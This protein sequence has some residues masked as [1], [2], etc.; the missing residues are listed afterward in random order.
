MMV[1]KDKCR[2]VKKQNVFYL[3]TRENVIKKHDK[4]LSFGSLIYTYIYIYIYIHKTLFDFLIRML[5]LF[6]IGRYSQ[7]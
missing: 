6:L 2:N 7:M 5:L 4:S 3:I 1:D